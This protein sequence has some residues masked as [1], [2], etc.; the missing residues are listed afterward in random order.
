MKVFK[1]SLLCFLGLAFFASPGP[2]HKLKMF[3]SAEGNVIAGY[4]YYTTGGKA[5]NATVLVKD[6]EE[7]TL[8]EVTTNTNGEFTFIAE[9]KRDYIFVLEL[10]NGHRT[11]FRLTADEL[12]DSLPVVNDGQAVALQNNQD[13]VKEAVK[14]SSTENP[15]EGLKPS[16]GYSLEE[17]ER[18]IDKAVAR[19]I[20]PLREQLEKYEE[21]IRLHD[22]LGG[23]GYI[24]GLMGLWLFL[25]VRKGIAKQ[26]R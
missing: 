20:R 17:I 22:I 14:T 5:K 19:Q 7:N 16:Q 25:G 3:A 24:I 23:I 11:T 1:Y 26:K 9:F 13:I 18:I 10:A 2:A 8:R 6:T 12:P 15:C 21:K 4:V